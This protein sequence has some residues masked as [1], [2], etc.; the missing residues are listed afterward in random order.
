MGDYTAIITNITLKNETPNHIR[1]L[2]DIIHDSSNPFLLK[3]YEDLMT[4]D[5]FKCPRW[6]I[7]LTGDSNYIPFRSDYYFN[8]TK[9]QS[10]SNIKNYHNE[11]ELFFDWIYPYCD[12]FESNTIGASITEEELHTNWWGTY[13]INN[14]TLVTMKDCIDI[15]RFNDLYIKFR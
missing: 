12:T 3:G 2:I 4:H 5:F 13:S 11:I 14:G 6:Q 7:L 15:R 9:L 10:I 8:G 1:R